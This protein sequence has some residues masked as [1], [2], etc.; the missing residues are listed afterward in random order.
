MDYTTKIRSFLAAA[1][2]GTALSMALTGYVTG[3]WNNLFH[4][5][6][7]AG[8][9]GLP[10]FAHD[11]FIQSLP[12]YASGFWLMLAGIAPGDAAFP[13]LLGCAIG[14]RFLTMIGFLACADLIGIRDMRSRLPFAVLIAFSTMA[15]GYA[16]A[17]AGG[18]FISYFT[19]SELANA[20]ILLTIWCAARGRFTA[21]F[22]LNGVTVFLNAFMGVWT[23]VPLALIAILLLVRREI[24]WRTLLRRMALGLAAFLILAAPVIR[25]ILSNPEFGRPVDFD[26]VRFLSE[27][28]PDHFL[29]RD[30]PGRSL[31]ALAIVTAAGTTAAVALAKLE[32]RAAFCLAALAGF[33]LLWLAGTVLPLLT[34]MPALLSL[35]LLRASVGIHLFGALATAALTVRWAQGP[36]EGKRRFWAPLLALATD[37]SRFLLPVAIVIVPLARHRGIARLRLDILAPLL[38]LAI[39]PVQIVLQARTNAAMRGQVATW[40]A[41]GLWAES[42]SA[43]DALF[44]VP[45][46]NVRNPPPVPVPDRTQQPLSAGYE[47]F[48]TFARRRI[49]VDAGS[50]GAV[51]WTPSYHHIWHRRLLEVLALR[52]HP[53]RMAY[54]KAHGIGFVIDGCDGDGI[55]AR[56]DGRCVYRV[57]P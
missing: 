5:P 44:L 57:M 47:V 9:P 49:W 30:L 29:V 38:F 53:A 7:L 13:L 43:P 10:Q 14:S 15:N 41:L 19:H 21:A 39:W 51:M 32:R 22:A 56:I 20:T 25:S 36:D 27:F 16:A 23:A 8:L 40:R 37:A 12:H 35:H 54:A 6:I 31:I 11:P 45:V 2:L 24:G 48:E 55:S 28:F 46:A 50:G 42:H 17:G 18:L 26:F 3:L 52:D 34:A 1:A 4:L 33:V